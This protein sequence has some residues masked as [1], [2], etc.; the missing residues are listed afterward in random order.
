[1]PLTWRDVQVGSYMAACGGA[2]HNIQAGGVFSID[3]MQA[4]F[5]LDAPLMA[6][7]ELTCARR[8]PPPCN[9]GGPTHATCDVGGLQVRRAPTR[10]CKALSLL[11]DICAALQLLRCVT[12]LVTRVGH[13]ELA[14]ALQTAQLWPQAL[15]AR[16]ASLASSL[17]S[18]SAARRAPVRAHGSSSS[19]AHRVSRACTAREA[20]EAAGRHRRRQ[21]QTWTGA[22]P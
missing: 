15:L 21:R 13:M 12:E 8:C 7:N 5:G 14:P 20:A 11:N 16:R 17:S 18:G 4:P 6:Y 3:L 19:T 22:P 10:A 9:T 1:M 2:N